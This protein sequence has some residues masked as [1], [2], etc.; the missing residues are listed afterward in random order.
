MASFKGKLS[1]SV[2][3]AVLFLVVNLPQTYQ[4]T[5]KII[6]GTVLSNGCP[7]ALGLLVHA[8]VFFGVS[9]LSMGR[10]DKIETGVKLKHSLYGTLIFFFLSN[11]VFYK[12]MGSMFGNGISDTLGCPTFL[13]ILISSIL[14]CTSLV[15]VM[16]LPN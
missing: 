12:L 10:S 5:N 14:Y 9:F 4:L 11:P 16:Y 15:G 2:F 13:G 7:T 1:I 6:P 8:L 3:S